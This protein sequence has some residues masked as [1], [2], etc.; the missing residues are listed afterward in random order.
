MTEERFTIIQNGDLFTVKDTVNKKPLGIFEFKEDEFPVYFCFHKII[1]L[2]NGLSEKNEDL[3]TRID[4]QAEQ[5]DRLY[6][7]I[8]AKDWS[9]LSDIIGDFKKCEE[10]LRIEEQTYAER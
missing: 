10:Q 5:L 8:E 3:K 9:A 1:D 2:L 6:G 4:R 7:L